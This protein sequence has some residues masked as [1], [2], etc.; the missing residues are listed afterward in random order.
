MSILDGVEHAVEYNQIS[1]ILLYFSIKIIIFT[2]FKH[3]CMTN[4]LPFGFK[5]I[6]LHRSTH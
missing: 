4:N 6:N 2:I 1:L 3:W 5:T